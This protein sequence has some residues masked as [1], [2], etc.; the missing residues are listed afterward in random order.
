MML[1]SS[2][3]LQ[4]MTT[5]AT[6]TFITQFSAIAST[7]HEGTLDDDEVGLLQLHHSTHLASQPVIEPSQLSFFNWANAGNPATQG[8]E[9]ELGPHDDAVF[10]DDLGPDCWHIGWISSDGVPSNRY[11]RGKAESERPSWS[12]DVVVSLDVPTN[13]VVQD[14]A[15]FIDWRTRSTSTPQRWCAETGQFC[16]DGDFCGGE[17]GTCLN[18]PEG[19]V[20]CMENPAGGCTGFIDGAFA[21]T[22]EAGDF[23]MWGPCGYDTD[24]KLTQN[25]EG[26]CADICQQQAIAP[27]HS[28]W[29]TC[30][31]ISLLDQDPFLID[32]G[33]CK[34]Y[35]GVSITDH[36]QCTAAAQALGK[37]PSSP[38]QRP[39]TP[40]NPQSAAFGCIWDAEVEEITGQNLWLNI[41]GN[42]SAAMPSGGSNRA[43]I[44][45]P[46]VTIVAGCVS[47][48]RR[49]YKPILDEP[50]CNKA[51]EMLS[52]PTRSIT[53]YFTRDACFQS[54][55]NQGTDDNQLCTAL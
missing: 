25:W 42:S 6:L 53:P 52:T 54:V 28:C 32:S 27:V 35:G 22:D 34:D 45:T 41:E 47:D 23:A 51:A 17:T 14:P 19:T 46:R 31:C 43:Q 44:C 30:S 50:S 5:S 21:I 8:F 2:F 4:T 15:C 26:S 40:I 18:P 10:G 9:W 7:E 49:T 55:S 29:Q 33:S 12:R 13:R 38:D 37:V 24:I 16:R 20:P 39:S 11:I 36:T 48:W 1:T 3:G